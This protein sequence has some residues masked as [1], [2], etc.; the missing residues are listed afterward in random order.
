MTGVI[1]VFSGERQFTLALPLSTQQYEWVSANQWDNLTEGWTG[2]HP[3]RV[4]NVF[5]CASCR[6]NSEKVKA[7]N[8]EA[9]HLTV[10]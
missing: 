4:A 5:V 10:I 2:I 8:Y 6:K 1:M 7:K 3:G 9:S